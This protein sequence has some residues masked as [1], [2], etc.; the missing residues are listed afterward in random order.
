[1]GSFVSRSAAR[2]PAAGQDGPDSRPRPSPRWRSASASTPRSSASSTRVLLR[3]TPVSRARPAGR[4]LHGLERGLPAAHHVVSGLPR[5][6]ARP[7]PRWRDRRQRLRAR[8]PVERRAPAAGHRRSGHGQL[9]R[10]AR[11][12]AGDRPRLPRGRERRRRRGRR[13]SCS[14]TGCG[15]ASSAAAANVVGETIE[16]SGLDYT[17]VGVAPRGFTGTMPGIPAEFWVPVMMVDRLAVLRRADVR[18]TTTPAP[19]GS[20]GAGTRWL[21][22][23]GR[24]ADGRTIDEARAQ[25]ETIFAR[26]RT[27]YPVTNEKV[28][29]SV[30]PAASIRFHPM[31]DGYVRAASAA[32]LAAVG[33][34]LLIACANVANMLLARGAAR[35]RELAIRAAIGASRGRLIR[36]LLSEGLVLAVGGRRA[37]RADRL[38]GGPRAVRVRQPDVFPIPISFDFSIDGTVLAF[39]LAASVAT[40]V[41]FGLAPAWSASK[42]ELVP[43]LKAST[44]RRRPPAAD[45]PRRAR[46]RPARAVARAA[47]RRRA[48][49]RG[50]LAARATDLGYDPRPVSSLSFNLQMNGYDSTRAMAL[51]ERALRALRAL[52]GVD[53]RVDRVAP[54][55]GARHQHGGHPRARATMRPATTE[56]RS[57]RSGRRRLLHGRGRADRRRPRLHRRRCRAA[58]GASRSSTRRWRGSTGRTARRSA[59][60]STPATSTS[61]PYEIVGVARDHKVRSVGE[62]PRP[63]LHLPEGPRARSVSSCARRRRGERRCRCCGRRCGRSSP[64]SSSPR[65]CPREQVAATTVAPTRIGAMVLGA[66]GALALLLAAVGLYGV[67]AYS[68]SRRTREVGIR[69]ALGAR[70]V[71]GPADDSR[72]GRPAGARRRRPRRAGR[73]RRARVLESLLYGVSGFDPLAYGAAAGVLLLVA[74]VANL[75]PALAAARVDPVRALRN[76]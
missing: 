71:A 46:R 1:M 38:V 69:M 65:T 51:R 62:A 17:I 28:T 37:R 6:P 76:E 5:H 34:V 12:P 13:S 18:P 59:G 68:V 73:G 42:P 39:A 20:S 35:R 74:F 55:A 21:F 48:A 56:R 44:G 60:R 33:L 75:V 57:T 26:L 9:L 29:A 61:A 4:D 72:P 58:S 8:H 64:T 63:Y 7:R 16:L 19:R 32:L 2:R 67:V 50:L 11:H 31:L 30:V 36:Q 52:P 70:T 40:A 25:I 45:A 66:F 47:R 24:L 23:K 3:D 14:A 15:S 53:R 27:D 43:A 54:A 22:V 41:L 49:R 10:R